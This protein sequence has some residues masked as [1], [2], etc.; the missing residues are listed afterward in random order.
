M[1][2]TSTTLHI[3]K[4]TNTPR[5]EHCLEKHKSFITPHEGRQTFA[6]SHLQQSNTSDS[7]TTTT[8]IPLTRSHT[9]DLH[10]RHSKRACDASCDTCAIRSRVHKLISAA[11]CKFLKLTDSQHGFRPRGVHSSSNSCVRAWS[12]HPSSSIHSLQVKQTHG[13]LGLALEALRWT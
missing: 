6:A 8:Q 12:M 11:Q 4:N 2:D 5:H 10:A 1:H 3:R 9:S 13:F 7:S